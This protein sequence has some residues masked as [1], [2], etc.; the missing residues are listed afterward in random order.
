MNWRFEFQIHIYGAR[1]IV[2]V[3]ST[4]FCYFSIARA[5]IPIRF[6]ETVHK[7]DK[8]VLD[9]YPTGSAGILDIFIEYK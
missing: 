8:V 6:R 1:N 3:Y 2:Y 7:S 5:R 4:L 9:L